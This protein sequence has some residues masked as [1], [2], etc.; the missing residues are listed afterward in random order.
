MELGE[1]VN[2]V[3]DPVS[4]DRGKVK[5]SQAIP[6]HCVICLEQITE[7]AI[8]VPCNHYTFDFLCLASWVQQRSACP[9]CRWHFARP[10]LEL[11]RLIYF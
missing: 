5:A 10:Y 1:V 3:I 6:D 7:R 2:E 11:W 4:I 8:S 9:L